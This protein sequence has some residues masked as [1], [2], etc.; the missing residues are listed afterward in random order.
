MSFTEVL[1][2][3]LLTGNKTEVGCAEIENTCVCKKIIDISVDISF[4][5]GSYQI[6]FIII[7]FKLQ[8]ITV[9]V[10]TTKKQIILP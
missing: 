5:I 10:E 1:T 4:F 6:N 3:E 8:L 7:C 2:T 9:F